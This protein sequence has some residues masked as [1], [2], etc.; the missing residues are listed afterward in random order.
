M[1]ANG[2]PYDIHPDGRFLMIEPRL[3]SVAESSPEG[4]RKIII[5]KNWFEELKQRVPVHVQ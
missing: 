5:V 1:P 2:I 3:I 4:P